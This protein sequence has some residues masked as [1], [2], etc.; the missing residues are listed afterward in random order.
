MNELDHDHLV[1]FYETLFSPTHFACIYK[2][3]VLIF[4]I[5]KS[6][7]LFSVCGAE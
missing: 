7:D 1:D 4:T 5:Y 6:T 3:S 2:P